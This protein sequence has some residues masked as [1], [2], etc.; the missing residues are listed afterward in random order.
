MATPTDSIQDFVS[1]SDITDRLR[2]IKETMQFVVARLPDS[3]EKAMLVAC[4][5][6]QIMTLP[7]APTRWG[8]SKDMAE[9]EKVRAKLESTAAQMQAALGQLNARREVEQ[10]ESGKNGILIPEDPQT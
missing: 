9:M 8:M 4:L 1:F 10:I 5:C 2:E 7:V 3:D 6:K